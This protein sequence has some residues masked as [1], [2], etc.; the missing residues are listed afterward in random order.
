MLELREL[1]LQ[2]A[3][4]SAR[5]LREDVEDQAAAIQHAAGELF[6]EVALLARR[7]R[8]IDDHE[9][10]AELGDALADFLDLAGAEEEARLGHLAR[11]R[12]DLEHLRARGARQRGEFFDAVRLRRVAEPDADEDRAFSAT[13]PFEQ[14]A[15]TP[16]DGRAAQAAGT[17]SAGTS[18]SPI[19]RRTLRAG[20]TVEMAC[21]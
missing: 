7:Q 9:V 20:T 11:D 19:G 14:F 13:G 17:S 8:V 6:L 12:H 16:R 10:G 5:A 18:S 15:L 4:E 21:L 1:D 2:L 3:F